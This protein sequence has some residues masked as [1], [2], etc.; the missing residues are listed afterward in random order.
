MAEDVCD[1]KLVSVSFDLQIFIELKVIM[2]IAN[3]QVTFILALIDPPAIII[4]FLGL[5]LAAIDFLRMKR[6][7]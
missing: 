5:T 6:T 3:L 7:L 2:T 1:N 4:L